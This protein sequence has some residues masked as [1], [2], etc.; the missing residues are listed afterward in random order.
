MT[1][2]EAP[3]ASTKFPPLTLVL[4]LLE[5]KGIRATEVVVNWRGSSN[6]GKKWVIEDR[7]RIGC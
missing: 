5:K 1:T 3:E 4:R 2:V 6:K 7:D